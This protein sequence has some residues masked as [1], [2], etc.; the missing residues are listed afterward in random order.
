MLSESFSGVRGVYRKD[1]DEFT[2]KRYAES[3]L[4]FLFK[5]KAKPLVVIG[6]DTRPSSESLKDAM[7]ETFLQYTDVIDVGINTTPAIEF[8]VRHLKADAGVIITASHNEPADNGWKLLDNTGCVL[9]PEGMSE[10]IAICKSLKL[11]A[12]KSFAGKLEEVDVSGAYA[13]FVL[14]CVGQD[15]VCLIRDAKLKA[16]VDPN[17]GSAAVV[18]KDILDRC[19][20]DVVGLNME[21]GVFKRQVIP[22]PETLVKVSDAVKSE[23]ADVGAGFDCDADRVELIDDK[24]SML[25]GQYVL[26]LLVDEVLS[27]YKG[28]DRS[29]VVNDATSN[30]VRIA[31][32]KYGFRVYEVEVGEV[33]VVRKM[34]SLKSPVG[35][36]GSSSGG[37]FPPSRCRDGILTLLMILRRMAR[38]KKSLSV[39][40]DVLPRYYT[41]RDALECRPEDVLRIKS[42]VEKFFAGQGCKIRRTGDESGGLKVIIDDNSWI[43][44]RESKTEAGKFRVMSDSDDEAKAKALLDKGV[45]AFKDAEEDVHKR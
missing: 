1:L 11:S 13:D 22:S 29:V 30:L 9:S 26:A 18:V 4:K 44:Y 41:L 37:I 17:G 45:K 14:D 21:L 42:A 34:D 16:V 24:G 27:N 2:A 20:V 33:N 12:R 15:G 6:R 5:F 31:A 39:L 28:F 32:E 3:F 40:Y 10:V 25:S 8:A 43:W 36:E 38:S 7:V 23:H 35:G 19:G